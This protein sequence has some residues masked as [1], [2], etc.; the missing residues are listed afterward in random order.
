[1]LLLRPEQLV[2]ID[3]QTID[4]AIPQFAMYEISQPEMISVSVPAAAVASGV[5][6]A[7]APSFTI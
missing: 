3:N 5:A 1:M 4:V 6:L 2:L 7:Y